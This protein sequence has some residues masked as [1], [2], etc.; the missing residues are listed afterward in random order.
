MPAPLVLSDA[1]VEDLDEF[2]RALEASGQH[3]WRSTVGAARTF[4]GRIDRAGGWDQVDVETQLEWMSKARPYLSWL[5][6]TG[7]TIA[8]AD[9]LALADIRLGL[10]ATKHLPEVRAWFNEA[11]ERVNTSTDDTSLQW[12]A[13]N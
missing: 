10:T 3:A 13:L 7:R 9:F 4:Q 6:V 8:S 5:L 12:N 1:A 11:A 2:T